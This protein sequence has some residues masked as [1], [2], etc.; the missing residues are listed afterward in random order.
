MSNRTAHFHAP[1]AVWSTGDNG[2]GVPPNT[3]GAEWNPSGVDFTLQ[4]GDVW[5]YEPGNPIHSIADLISVYHKCVES[6]S[7]RFFSPQRPLIRRS[8]GANG[9]LELDFAI[10][11]TGQVGEA[12]RRVSSSGDLA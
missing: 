12:N 6:C 2:P 3:T 7:P 5:F 1:L 10:D 4:I 11:R 9:K 8:V